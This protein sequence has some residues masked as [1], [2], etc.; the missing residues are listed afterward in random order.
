[1]TDTLSTDRSTSMPLSQVDPIA[2]TDV[3]AA[4]ESESSTIERMAASTRSAWAVHHD[5]VHSW[6][7]RR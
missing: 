4:A 5:T 6:L 3:T 2:V 1:M 7:D